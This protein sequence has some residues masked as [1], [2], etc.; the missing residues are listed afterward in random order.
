MPGVTE[1]G[2]AEYFSSHGYI[3][4]ISLFLLTVNEAIIVSVRQLQKFAGQFLGSFE[5]L[6]GGA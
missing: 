6:W 1:G 2:E 4:N 5:P 3:Q